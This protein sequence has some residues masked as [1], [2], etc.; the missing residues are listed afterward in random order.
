MIL[1]TIVSTTHDA[2]H[3]LRDD[4]LSSLH[5][6]GNPVAGCVRAV[7]APSDGGRKILREGAKPFPEPCRHGE[8]PPGAHR[9]CVPLQRSA[10][11]AAARPQGVFVPDVAVAAKHS[12]SVQVEPAL[13][14]VWTRRVLSIILPRPTSNCELEREWVSGFAD[15][16]LGE[17]AP[18]LRI[19]VLFDLI[20]QFS[21]SSVSR[22]LLFH[23]CVL[24]VLSAGAVVI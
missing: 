18:R 16:S 2:R 22:R 3:V 15:A 11:A 13:R 8:L 7:A 6:G 24:T 19:V 23:V 14:C 5:C 4:E 10:S 1:P 20:N 21:G 17:D 9:L 12:N